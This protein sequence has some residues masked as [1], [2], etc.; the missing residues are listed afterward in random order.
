MARSGSGCHT[1]DELLFSALLVMA[2]GAVAEVKVAVA[3]TGVRSSSLVGRSVRGNL[4][5]SRRDVVRKSSWAVAAAKASA[6]ATRT[7][8]T[9]GGS[10][11]VCLES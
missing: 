1:K 5:E 9:N 4:K 6:S 10:V 7:I 2:G 11:G 3:A 8:E